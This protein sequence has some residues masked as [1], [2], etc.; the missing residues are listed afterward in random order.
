MR[1]WSIT[2]SSASLS[3]IIAASPRRRPPPARNARRRT[4]FVACGPGVERLEEEAA[5]LFPDKRILV[6]SSDLIASIERMREE[7]REIDARPRRY[8]HRHAA[9]RQGPS[10]SEAQSG[11]RD[12]CRSRPRLGR[13]ARCRAHVPAAAS[14]DRPRRARG[15][16]RHRLSADASAG[17]SGDEGADRAGPRGV[18]RLAKSRRASAPAIR[19]SGGSR[20]CSSPAPTSTP[21]KA[22]RASSRPPRR[23]T[24]EV[25]VLGPAEAPL[26]VV[27]GRHRFRL[28]VKSARNFDLSG[29]L[30]G[31]LAM[32][33]S[34]RATSSSRSMSTRRVFCSV[35]APAAART[36]TPRR[37]AHSRR[38][39]PRS[40]SRQAAIAVETT[41]ITGAL[42]TP[43][44][45]VIA[46][47]RRTIPNHRKYARPEPTNPGRSCRTPQARA[48][49]THAANL[50]RRAGDTVTITNA[51]NTCHAAFTTGSPVRRAHFM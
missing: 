9:C 15:R 14:G 30:R 29:Y 20:A 50:R 3:A 17:A 34:A 13:S 11:R 45:A 24:E 7:F 46:G 22:S 2:A 47:T 10:F 26:A 23:A 32:R 16:P 33:R 27:R 39:P 21:R 35:S 36:P 1:G 42:S 49:A 43:S 19:R 31:W 8:R 28:M 5:E 37:S 41:P 6:L 18:L 25:R 48:P 38:C 12:R 4:R 40:D 44:D 51:T